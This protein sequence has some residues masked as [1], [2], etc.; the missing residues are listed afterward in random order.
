MSQKGKIYTFSILSAAS[1]DFVAK[2]PYVIAIIESDG[3]RFLT[4]I[5]NYNENM[6]IE[7]GSEVE[8]AGEENGVPLCKVV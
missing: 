4:R 7:V 1:E 5:D 8:L 2:L 3:K 6:K